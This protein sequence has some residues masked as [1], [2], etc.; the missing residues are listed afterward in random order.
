MVFSSPVTTVIGI[1]AAS[2][3]AVYAL[4]QSGTVDMKTLIVS[5]G[6]A[7]LGAA[8]KDGNK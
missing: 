7:A 5:A 3:N 4:V 8:G 2:L 6:I 1:L